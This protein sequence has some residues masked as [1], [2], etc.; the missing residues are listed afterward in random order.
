MTGCLP[1]RCE[2]AKKRER[3]P[4]EEFELII[5]PDAYHLFDWQLPMRKFLGH[6]LAYDEQATANSRKG[7]HEFFARYLRDESPGGSSSARSGAN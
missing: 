6:A 3:T 7:M 2:E 4:G 1:P 5:Y